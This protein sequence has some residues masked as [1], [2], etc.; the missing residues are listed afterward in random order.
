[1]LRMF[2]GL[3]LIA[4]VLRLDGFTIVAS[5]EV[6][7]FIGKSA[8]KDEDRAEFSGQPLLQAFDFS[9]TD[10]DHHLQ[11]IKVIPDTK[12]KK[13]RVE[14]RDDNGDDLF[15]WSASFF[16]INDPR[17]HLGTISREARSNGFRVHKL[18]KPAGNFVFVLTGF[19]LSYTVGD[20]HIDKIGVFEEA[21]DLHVVMNDKNN[22]D[23]F[24][25]TINYA[26]VP[27]DLVEL[28]DRVSGSAKGQDGAEIALGTPVLSGFLFNYSNKDHHI[29]RISVE[30][31]SGNIQVAYH[32][33]NSDDK[34]S[35]IVDV[36]I[37]K[38]NA[39][40]TKFNP[41]SLGIVG[42]NATFTITNSRNASRRRAR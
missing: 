11:R 42:G 22:D 17:I 15:N 7:E 32:D 28:T 26:Y 4:L 27:G 1:M 6:L 14:F 37:L 36:S 33:K 24:F 5:A 16:E 38:D 12:R 40:P 41:N 9:F 13:V 19:S 34:F 29:R 35:W 21:G 10:K 3:T 8:D 18:Q 30:S 23:A 2:C 39:V 31:R 20:H 25:Y